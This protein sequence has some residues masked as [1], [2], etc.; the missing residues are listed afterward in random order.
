GHLF[1][2]GGVLNIRNSAHARDLGPIDPGCACYTCRHYTRSYLRHLDRCNEILG[3]RLNTLHNLHFYLE[4]MRA[5][6]ASIAAGAFEAF[7]AA[8]PRPRR[9]QA[10]DAEA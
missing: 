2:P 7:A 8:F 5:I 6:R 10:V 3:C 4:L 1:V 9:S